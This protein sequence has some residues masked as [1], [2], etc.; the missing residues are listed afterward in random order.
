MSKRTVVPLLVLGLL[1]I[2]ATTIT[3]ATA[4]QGTQQR[5]FRAYAP[6][7]SRAEEPP[8]TPT[9]APVPVLPPEP[10][11]SNAPIAAFYLERAGIA[12]NWPVE[13]G[14]TVTKG[15]QLFFADPV[16]PQ[17]IVWYPAYGRPG[18]RGGNTL[19]A[20]HV[21]YYTG[22]RTPFA[23]ITRA[24]AGDLLYVL[25]TDG[26]QYTYTVKSVRVVALAEYNAEEIVYPPLDSY[27]ERLTFISCG[28]A[29]IPN[30]VLGYG[31]EYASRIVLIAERQLP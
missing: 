7:V 9:P 25:L 29:F 31:G 19:A 8:P 26:T 5:P 2:L 18:Y 30:T 1:G 15:G 23:A 20:G 12:A 6:A 22:V 16:N 3:A 10:T 21:D 11:P 14:G 27:T 28:G 13:E 4:Q 17:A 24:E